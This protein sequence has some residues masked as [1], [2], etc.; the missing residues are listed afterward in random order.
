MTLITASSRLN[1]LGRPI[2]FIH[3]AYLAIEHYNGKPACQLCIYDFDKDATGMVLLENAGAYSPEQPFS[4]INALPKGV[5]NSSSILHL[6][7]ERV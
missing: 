7:V 1:L 2:V 3:W 4:S 5:Y 6:Q